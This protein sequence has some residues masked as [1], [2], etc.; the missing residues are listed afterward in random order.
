MRRYL[1]GPRRP[2]TK[3]W[4]DRTGATAAEYAVILAVVS[5]A[6][7]MAIS[8]LSLSISGGLDDATGVIESTASI[9]GDAADGNCDNSG[10]GTGFGGGAGGGGGQ[11]AGQGEG[12][13]CP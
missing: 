6:L 8:L 2:L 5:G 9:D 4:L 7:V 11:G 3:I 13:T 10:L 12:N 1:E